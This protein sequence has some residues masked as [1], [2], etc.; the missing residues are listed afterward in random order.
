MLLSLKKIYFSLG[1]LLLLLAVILFILY[2]TAGEIKETSL[3]IKEQK[4]KLEELYKKGQLFNPTKK[5]YEEI[6]SE[7]PGLSNIFIAKNQ[8]LK[9]I[10]ALEKIAQE[11]N[12]IQK[13]NLE[14]IPQNEK[15]KKPDPQKMSLTIKLNG[16]YPN[17][18][19]YLSALEALDYYINI[20]NLRILADNSSGFT[21][22]EGRI[23]TK[24][25]ISA[26]LK[27][28]VFLNSL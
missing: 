24:N 20:N 6:S 23:I 16:D 21:V 22:P 5:Q 25:S 7:L 14:E 27:A 15:D 1:T 28:N 17:L 4:T 19:K 8:E 3:E 12:L 18:I 13:I 11:N 2:P 26:S 10:T 9:L